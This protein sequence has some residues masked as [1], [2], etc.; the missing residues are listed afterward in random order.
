MICPS[1]QAATHTA[2]VGIAWRALRDQLLVTSRL[3]RIFGSQG[4]PSKLSKKS[5]KVSL[6]WTALSNTP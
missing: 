1:L 6:P 2:S 3:L 4:R 5:L